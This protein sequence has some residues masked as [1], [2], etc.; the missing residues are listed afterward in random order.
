MPAVIVS[1]TNVPVSA[2]VLRPTGGWLTSDGATLTAVYAG[3]AGEDQ[4][5]GRL[6]IV[7]QDLREGSQTEDIVNVPRK[8]A[9]SIIHAPLGTNV[10]TSAQH[11]DIDFRGSDGSTGTLDLTDDRVQAG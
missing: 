3:T 7:R 1:S 6:V 8:G 5:L 2:S 10:E 11:G 9:L 4:T